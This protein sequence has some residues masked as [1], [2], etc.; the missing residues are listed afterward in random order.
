LIRFWFIQGKPY[1]V[2]NFICIGTML[3]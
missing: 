1:Y 3:C 2:S